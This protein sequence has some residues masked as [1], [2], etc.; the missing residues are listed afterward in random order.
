MNHVYTTF[1]LIVFAVLVSTGQFVGEPITCWVP[2]EWTGAFEGYTKNYC[3]IKNTYYIPLDDVIPRDIHKRQVRTKALMFL[4]H[5]F[6]IVF[7]LSL[8]L[9]MIEPVRL[10]SHVRW[11]VDWVVFHW[12]VVGFVWLRSDGCWFRAIDHQMHSTFVA[13]TDTFWATLSLYRV[14]LISMLKLP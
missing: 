14:V 5:H 10:L 7:L 3:W 11:F 9:S 8:L 12:M 4:Q 2:A 13:S 6:L 1:G